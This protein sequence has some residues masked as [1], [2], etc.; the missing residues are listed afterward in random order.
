MLHIKS[1]LTYNEYRDA[2]RFGTAMR[3]RKQTTAFVAVVAFEVVYYLLGKSLGIVP[4]IPAINVLAIA[5]MLIFLYGVSQRERAAADYM[6]RKDTLIGRQVEYTF[7]DTDVTVFVPDPVE[8]TAENAPTAEEPPAEEDAAEEVPAAEEAPG[9]RSTYTLDS[10]H[11]VFEM[12]ESFMLCPTVSQMF[13][14]GKTTLPADDAGA[15]REF[16]SAHLADKFVSNPDGKMSRA[17]L[18]AAQKRFFA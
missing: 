9:Q 13:I 17:D 6:H 3:L 1:T 14:I 10:L 11:C 4:Y 5:Y 18:L 8:E 15:L 12:P 7:T 16:L 2:L